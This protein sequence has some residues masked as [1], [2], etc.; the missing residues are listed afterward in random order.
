VSFLFD[1]SVSVDL[2]DLSLALR[3]FRS[4]EQMTT[5]Q[6]LSMLNFGGEVNLLRFLSVRAG[7]YGGYLSAGV[8][9][10]IFLVDIN[11]AIAGDFGRDA[12]DQWGFSN[13]GGSVEFAFRL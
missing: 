8:G 6:I 5:D 12:A 10:D 3:T 4:G 9:L 13:V 7:Y 1:P 11:A 2:L